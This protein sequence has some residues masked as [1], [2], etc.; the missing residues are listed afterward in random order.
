MNE[1]VFHGCDCPPGSAKGDRDRVFVAK[2]VT[3][4]TFLAWQWHIRNESDRLFYILTD[5]LIY[6]ILGWGEIKQ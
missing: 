5:S 2:T 6:I 3:I 1:S 4:E